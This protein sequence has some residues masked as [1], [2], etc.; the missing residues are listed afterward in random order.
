MHFTV[1]KKK[2]E[3]AKMKKSMRI[4]SLLLCLLM[5][6]SAMS[7]LTGCRRDEDNTDQTVNET[8][9]Q[10]YVKYYNAGFGDEWLNRLCAEFEAMYADVSF[11]EGKR[12]VQIMKEFNRGMI[13]PDG[14]KGNR[15]NVYLMENVDY[16]TFVSS[17]MLLDLTDVINDY[18]VTGKDTKE[19]AK[20]IA[21][22]ILPV[23]DEYLNIS[24]RYYALPLYETSINLNY[25]I[26]L[27][28]ERGLY[29]A[30]G[31]TAENFTEADFAD[32]SKIS[33]LF[34]NNKSDARANGPDG[35]PGTPDDGLPATYK[36]FRALTIY[37]KVAG[38]TPFIWNGYETGYLTGLVNDMWANN[39]GA[40][41][42]KL[43]FT[44]EGTANDLIRLDDAG[45][46]MRNADG[47][48]QLLPATAITESNKAMLQLQKGKL[49][50]IT[51]AKMLIDDGLGNANSA[52]YYNKSFDS[53]F[54]HL[55]AQSYFLDP[56]GNGVDPIGFLVDG[57]WWYHE[58]GATDR[59]IGILPLP[60]VDASHIGEPNTKIS[61]RSTLAFIS[62]ETPAQVQPAAKAFYS[63]LHSDYS[64]NI[65]TKYTEAFRGMDYE[66]SDDTLSSLSAYGK[67]AVATRDGGNTVL[68]WTPVSAAARRNASMLSYRTYG[69]S[70]NSQENNPLIYFED[71][72]DA[73]VES[74]FEAIWKYRNR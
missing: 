50:A 51:F 72:K 62:S 32:E 57:G 38:V 53:G 48:V 55:N 39:E 69:F 8:K 19:S 14:M 74:Y 64:L 7:V 24:G 30:A 34:V 21:D 47:T 49:D 13:T 44:F 33:A 23:Y 59:N 46:V 12:G 3:Y 68:P 18:A 27:F 65:Y 4:L 10:L 25:D 61:D 71:H 2:K 54:S 58:S 67:S 9:T 56:Y 15:N 73:T 41:Q 5:F 6:A 22:K 35:K 26:D 16:Y 1:S 29:F 43:N 70:V 17:G 11:E 36:D 37:M 40:A 31:K 20:K 42:M 52:N 28:E 60:K 63:F 45:H 66:L